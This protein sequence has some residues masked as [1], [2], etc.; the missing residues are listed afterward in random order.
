MRATKGAS[1]ARS[2][3]R[4]NMAG[5]IAAPVRLDATG[6]ASLAVNLIAPGSESPVAEGGNIPARPCGPATLVFSDEADR[7]LSFTGRRSLLS[8]G[9]DHGALSGGRRRDRAE[10]FH[11]G[12]VARAQHPGP[13]RERPPGGRRLLR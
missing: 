5:R 9:A 12:V 10:I 4:T 11:L 8:D 13:G 6:R 7:H 3:R 1:D 2:R